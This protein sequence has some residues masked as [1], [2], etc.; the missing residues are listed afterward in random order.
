MNLYGPY[1]DRKDLWDQLDSDGMLKDPTL[2]VRGDLILVTLIRE[3]WGYNSR[4]YGI[5]QYFKALFENL[6]LVDVEKNPI[7][8]TWK[9]GKS[10]DV[11]M[12]K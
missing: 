11:R 8:P 2:I 9:N 10:G 7:R 1:H 3:V 6:G 5:S 4:T 12:A